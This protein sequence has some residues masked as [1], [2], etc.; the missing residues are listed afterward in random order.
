MH[1][2]QEDWDG[3]LSQTK[4]L[5]NNVQIIVDRF[6]RLGITCPAEQ[7]AANKGMTDNQPAGMAQMYKMLQDQQEKLFSSMRRQHEMRERES[8]PNVP[9]LALTDYV[10]R[11]SAACLKRLAPEQAFSPQP[12]YLKYMQ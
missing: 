9:P 6:C 8:I 1:Y 10:D 2:T 4:P 5:M 12:S 7:E 3:F 11:K